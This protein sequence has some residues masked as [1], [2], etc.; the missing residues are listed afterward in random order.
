MRLYRKACQFG[1]QV[2]SQSR[3]AL[4]NRQTGVHINLG[5]YIAP[6]VR[7]RIGPGGYLRLVNSQLEM[8]CCVVVDQSARLIII[9]SFVGF[10]SHLHAKQEITIGPGS[11]LAEFVSVR[12]APAAPIQIGANTWI[13]SRAQIHP[14]VQV[15]NNS[16]IG[17]SS[18][19]T[20]TVESDAV[21]VGQP[22]RK[23]RDLRR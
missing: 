17:A 2:R 5:S 8:G 13:A 7:I 9:D 10:H 20:S 6:H 23:V 16:V 1:D 14:G 19:V 11:K 12:D 18:V 22:V 21:Y 15:G 4:L 3:I